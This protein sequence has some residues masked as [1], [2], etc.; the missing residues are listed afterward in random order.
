MTLY[1]QVWTRI[2]LVSYCL[3]TD[4]LMN[5]LFD[6][7]VPAAVSYTHLDVY[8]RQVIAYIFLTWGLTGFLS[9]VRLLGPVSYTH[10]DVYKRQMLYFEFKTI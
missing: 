3:Q 4:M 6:K 10:L 1:T 8:K 5:E 9:W 7:H 2:Q